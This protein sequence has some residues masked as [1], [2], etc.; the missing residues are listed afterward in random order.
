MPIFFAFV[1][2]GTLLKLMGASGINTM[3]AP[4]PVADVIELPYLFNAVTVTLI[5][6]PSFREKGYYV[7]VDNGIIQLKSDTILDFVPSQFSFSFR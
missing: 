3:L 1:Y 4:L 7:S 2:K 6:S 5:L